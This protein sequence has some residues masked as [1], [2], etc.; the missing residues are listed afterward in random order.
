MPWGDEPYIVKE[1]IPFVAVLGSLALLAAVSRFGA[2]FWVLLFATVC[3]TA[4]FRNPSRPIPG[5]PKAVVC[6]A[7]GRVLDVES[8]SSPGM[9]PV[10]C[11][12]ISIFMSP[13]DVHVNRVPATGVVTRKAHKPGRFLVASTAAASSENER[14]ELLIETPEGLTL[15]L[16]QIAGRM[17][18]RIVCY[19]AEGDTVQRGK[20]LGLIRFGSRVE[21]FL[22]MEVSVSVQPGQRV[23]GG[24]TVMGYLP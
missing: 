4:F 11:R 7:D 21:L 9:I 23:K 18:R 5:N 2:L 16:I 17:A 10:P 22:P 19:P 8:L 6:P 14:T 20:R 24:A 1:A 15:G 12:K 13:L 3:V